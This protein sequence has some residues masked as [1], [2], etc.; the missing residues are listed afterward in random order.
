MMCQFAFA[1]PGASAE[2]RLEPVLGSHLQTRAPE[3]SYLVP[4]SILGTCN[5]DPIFT[6][7]GEY[8]CSLGKRKHA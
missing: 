7:A 3:I 2:L 4:T 6:A 1:K 5:S 8:F